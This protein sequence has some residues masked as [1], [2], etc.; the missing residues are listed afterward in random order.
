MNLKQTIEYTDHLLHD[1][2]TAAVR[3]AAIKTLGELHWSVDEVGSRFIAART[4]FHLLTWGEK[5]SID[6]SLE[7]TLRATSSSSLSKTLFD[8]GKNRKNIEKLFQAMEK[9]V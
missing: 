7:G 5:V 8:W 9:L 1:H 4:P 2:D 6:M 3:D